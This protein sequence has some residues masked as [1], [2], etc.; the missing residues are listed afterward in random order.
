MSQLRRLVVVLLAILVIGGGCVVLVRWSD[1]DFSNRYA[2]AGYFD[3]AGQGLHSGSEVVFRGVQVGEVSTMTLSG[4]K[5][6][7]VML[8]DQDFRVPSDATAT[9]G[10]INLFGADQVSLTTPKEALAPPFLS[11]GSTIPKTVDSDDL[12]D[13]FAAATPLLN[14]IN[15]ND[16]STV[17][18]ELAEGSA[19]EGPQIAASFREGAQLAALLDSTLQAQLAALDSF[20]DFAGALAPSTG[21]INALSAQ[22]NLAL[23]TFN[24]DAADYAKL[25][26]AL[27]PFAQDLSTLLT[28]YH[29]DIAA[30]IANGDNVAR[31]FTA[32]A[33]DVGTLIQGLYEYVYKLGHA[34]S[35][36]VLPDGS[37]FGYF[38][39]FILFSD[40]NQLICS[41]IAPD[42]P[43]LSFLEPLQEAL[44][45]SGSAF[46]C[47]SELAQFDS[48]Q[49]SLTGAGT[50]D[51]T[52]S[53]LAQQALQ[54][55]DNQVYG[56]LG[57]PSNPVNQNISSYIDS[58]L[59]GGL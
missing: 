30:L 59:G 49:S 5:A 29:P 32:H 43:D 25:L 38:N 19:G 52:S 31:V 11:P 23:P 46:N 45:G 35:P 9:I 58:L 10:P 2:L 34:V 51:P 20:A 27:T 4:T 47:S 15:T 7:V 22:E 54:S 16:L 6:R 3:G 1:G 36:V 13:L 42:E 14:R 48:L 12:G 37:R 21:A 24:A 50:P 28:D 55:I 53:A 39:T 56:I 41:L 44:A 40:V 8:I 17:V 33:S 26:A 57:Q 18:S